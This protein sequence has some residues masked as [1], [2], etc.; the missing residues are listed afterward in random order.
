MARGIGNK[1]RGLCIWVLMVVGLSGVT[2]GWASAA[3]VL[4]ESE[5]PLIIIDP[6]HGGHV[7]GAAGAGGTLEKNV[8]LEFA[9][10]LEKTLKPDYRVA[11]TRTGDYRV[12][13][14]KRAS[15][16]NYKR[17]ACF[18]S[19]H[20][21]GFPRA[22]IDAWSVYAFAPTG[23]RH[24]LPE[25]ADNMPGSDRARLNW[26]QIQTKYIQASKTLAETL[27][28]NLEKCPGIG[29]V[30]SAEAPLLLLEGIDMPAVIVEAGYLT[31]PSCESRLNDPDF[32]A[33]AAECLRHGIDAF[34][35]EK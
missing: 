5:Q 14:Q 4:A 9:E 35:L 18:I 12:S 13:L 17:G 27:T 3:A 25:T 16:A 23:K 11:L 30:K 24:D 21:G 28:V 33:A 2:V 8:A 10:I 19:L 34:F 6:G 31:N 20:S 29:T 1:S 15:M 22:G 7:T 26:R 32:L